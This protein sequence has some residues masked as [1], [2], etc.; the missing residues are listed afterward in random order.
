MQQSL[1]LAL[2][3]PQ[4]TAPE[5]HAFAGALPDQHRLQ[6]KAKR[7]K[8]TYSVEKH[9]CALR[10]TGTTVASKNKG[11]RACFMCAVKAHADP[12]PPPPSAYLERSTLHAVICRTVEKC[13]DQAMHRVSNDREVR[14]VPADALEGRPV[15]R[16]VVIPGFGLM[17]CEEKRK[18]KKTKKGNILIVCVRLLPFLDAE[19][20]TRPP[21]P[22][23]LTQVQS[24]PLATTIFL[25][26]R[27]CTWYQ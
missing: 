12:P 17:F 9:A 11:D 21:R 26:G 10:Y 8:P 1:P 6:K 22:R 15:A 27:S 18:I 7:R 13:R 4:N 23:A 2:P 5:L 16:R 3:V 25:S 19:V 14:A 24:I 20:Y